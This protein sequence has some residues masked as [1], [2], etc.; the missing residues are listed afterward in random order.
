MTHKE[1][2][3]TIKAAIKQ[4][5]DDESVPQRQTLRELADPSRVKRHTGVYPVSRR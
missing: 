4:L 1:L 3:N 2:L 5:A